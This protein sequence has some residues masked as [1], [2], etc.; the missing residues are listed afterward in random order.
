MVLEHWYV[1]L[2]DW[3]IAQYPALLHMYLQ[4]RHMITFI[5]IK[6]TIVYLGH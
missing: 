1:V 5:L 6:N 3:H 2:E 4:L